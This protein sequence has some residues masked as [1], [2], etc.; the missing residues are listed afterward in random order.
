MKRLAKPLALIIVLA[1]IGGLL[2]SACS[3]AATPAPAAKQEPPKQAEQGTKQEP[4]K[5]AKPAAK[6]GTGEPIKVGVIIPWT[7]RYAP[8]GEPIKEAIEFAGE[9]INASG[10]V[11]GRKLDLIFYDD[12]ADQ[13]KATQLANKAINQ[14]KVV[15]IIGSAVTANST[16]I[17]AAAEKAQ[18]VNM[19]MGP[20]AKV[21]EGKKYVFQVNPDV[22]VEAETLLEYVQKKLNKKAIAVL[23]DENPYGV[24]SSTAVKEQADKRG[25]K[26]VAMEK[27]GGEDTDVTP[28]LTKIK[29]SGAEAI[30]VCGTLPTPAIAIKQVKQLG[31]DLPFLGETGMATAQF[32]DVAKEA[33]EGAYATTVISYDNTPMRQQK[34]IKDFKAKFGSNPSFF[35]ALGWDSV[36]IPVAGIQKAGGKTD[37]DSIAKGIESLKDYQGIVGVRNFTP[38]N[39]NGLSYES[40]FIMTVKGGKWVE[41]PR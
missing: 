24:E 3:G 33:A 32:I 18:I 40:L 36:Q 7:G 39:H 19:Y 13:A 30:L 29:N 38:T 23:Y 14:D 4:A 20:S 31:I 27:Y 35:S 28:Q 34:F 11:S 1:F 16:V 21:R 9:Q 15:A 26:V 22:A 25:V 12:E 2:L 5:E 37:G 41:V 10:G 17:A 6:E 8:M